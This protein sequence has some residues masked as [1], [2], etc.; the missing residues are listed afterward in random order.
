MA[1]NI[2]PSQFLTTKNGVYCVDGE[3]VVL[4]SISAIGTLKEDIGKNIE[5]ERLKGFL[6]RHGKELGES[7][8]RKAL[9]MNL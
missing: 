5:K 4:L 9:T 8:A 3:R 2:F 6:I 7:D 1:I